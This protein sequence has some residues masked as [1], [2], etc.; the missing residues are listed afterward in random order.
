MKSIKTF[1]ALFLLS[2]MG[3]FAKAQEIS[4]SKPLLI[5]TMYLNATLEN[6]MLNIDSVLQIMKK[7][8]LEPNPYYISS[9]IVSHWYGHDSREVLIL[10][11]LKSW[12][13]ITR[14]EIRQ[15]EIIMQLK[16]DK[17]MQA[18]GNMW[19]SLIFPEHHSDEIYRV[20]AE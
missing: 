20:V 18:A 4:K 7:N 2:A 11:E 19:E 6:R 10:T 13:D 17:N 8:I 15:D 16:K 9:K 1:S 5:H 14:A 3:L 12:D